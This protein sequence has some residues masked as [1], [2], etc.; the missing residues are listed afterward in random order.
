MS[1]LFALLSVGLGVMMA[2]CSPPS[3]PD[4]R[5]PALEESTPASLPP[6]GPVPAGT[7]ALHDRFTEALGGLLEQAKRNNQVDGELFWSAVV[8][9]LDQQLDIPE[10]TR[11]EFRRSLR[12]ELGMPPET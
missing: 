3:E 12:A 2:S 5:L 4:Q 10:S 7:E 9:W 6:L 11:A 8:R 1:R